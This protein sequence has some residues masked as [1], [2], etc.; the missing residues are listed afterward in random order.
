VTTH[1]DEGQ[2]ARYAAGADDLPDAVV[3][4]VEVHLESCSTCRERLGAGINPAT[5]ALVG[6]VRLSLDPMPPPAPERSRPLNAVRRWSTWSLLPRLA[7]TVG[8]LLAVLE[9]DILFDKYPSPVLLMAPIAPLFG[10]AAVCSRR[11]DPAWEM[12]AASPQGGIQLVLRRTITVLAAV[13]PV[14]AL[15]GWASG[16]SPALWLPPCLTTTSATL[17]LGSR[18]GVSRAAAVVAAG[19]AGAVAAPAIVTLRLPAVLDTNSAPGWAV[20]SLALAALIWARA[21]DFR[22]LNSHN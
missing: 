16:T 10:V 14:L 15:V 17:A 9:L 6:Q 7:I 5:A 8:A 3:W 11:D 22:R 12:V 13:V 20:A 1:I 21:D 2:L 4:S 19:W 18:L